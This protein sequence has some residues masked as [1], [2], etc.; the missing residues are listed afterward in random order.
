MPTFLCISLIGLY[1]NSFQIKYKPIVRKPEEKRLLG[2]PRHRWE[3]N[4]KMDLKE[5]DCDNMDWTYLAKL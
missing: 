3:N 1:K 4:I 5:I 2:R